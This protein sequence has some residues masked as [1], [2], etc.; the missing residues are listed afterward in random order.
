MTNEQIISLVLTYMDDVSPAANS[1]TLINT[2]HPIIPQHLDYAAER[3]LE[4]LPV[5]LQQVF[6]PTGRLTQPQVMSDHV[7]L[8]CPADFI[9]LAR[10]KL[11][12]WARP[13][14]RV[15]NE[16]SPGA[17]AQSYRYM[18]GSA[19]RPTAV[20]VQASG[21]KFALE[22]RPVGSG[23]GPDMFLYVKRRKAREI[24][25][26]LIDPLVW[27][28]AARVFDT[29][30][31]TGSAKVCYEQLTNFIQAAVIKSQN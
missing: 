11:P 14:T 7:Y 3:L 17:I 31:D 1:E 21:N 10:V 4:M 22:L 13:V 15:I 24:E 20:L 28:I 18:G 5:S 12:S 2:V 19:L 27:L 30:K 16:N 23:Q 6:P 8:E 29:I 9:K 26:N 25:D